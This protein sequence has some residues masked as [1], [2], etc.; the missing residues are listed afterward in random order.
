[1]E[2]IKIKVDED[3]NFQEKEI[4]FFHFVELQYQH[5]V[6]IMDFY[7]R[8]R[9]LVIA[10]LKKNGDTMMCDKTTVPAEDEA[11]SPT[12][13]ELIFAVVLGLID[14]RLPGLVRDTYYHRIGKTKSILDFKKDI[15]DKVPSL[16]TEIK[17]HLPSTQKDEADTLDRCVT[18]M[19]LV[20]L[21]IVDQSLAVF[22]FPDLFRYLFSSYMC[23]LNYG[24]LRSFS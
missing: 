7:N 21:K 15:F 10:N 16:L 20:K 24:T 18:D 17:G 6:S 13:E 1:M 2:I 14:F 19:S 3:P 4:H 5:N 9:N 11:L 8:Y 22:F 23:I 12:F